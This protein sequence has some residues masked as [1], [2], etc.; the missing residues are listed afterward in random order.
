MYLIESFEALQSS[1]NNLFTYFLWVIEETT[2]QNSLQLNYEDQLYKTVFYSEALQITTTTSSIFMS[3]RYSYKVSFPPL[4][5]HIMSLRVFIY[6]TH[7]KVFYILLLF[8]I[9]ETSVNYSNN[10]SHCVSKENASS[11]WNN[12]CKETT[13]YNLLTYTSSQL[14]SD[15]VACENDLEYETTRVTDVQR[16]TSATLIADPK[17]E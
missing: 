12:W 14:C 2:L 11:I 16:N 3:T 1:P 6:I 9:H 13:Y 7:V 4:S 8:T 15:C 17:H 10:I 5:A